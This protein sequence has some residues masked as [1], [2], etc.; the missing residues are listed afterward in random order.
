MMMPQNIVNGLVSLES[1]SV[2]DK[3]LIRNTNAFG[4]AETNDNVIPEMPEE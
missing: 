1:C 2:S 3:V 4:I